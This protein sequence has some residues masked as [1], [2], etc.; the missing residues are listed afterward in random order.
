VTIYELEGRGLNP[1]RNTFFS[2][3]YKAQT[4]S[5]AHSASYPM[6]TGAFSSGIKR[7]GRE[8]DHSPPFSA[9][10]KSVGDIPPFPHMPS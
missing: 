9:E 5:E 6:G 10:V 3:L 1:D 4:N 2:L 8:V 7:P